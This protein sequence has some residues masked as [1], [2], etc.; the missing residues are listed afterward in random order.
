MRPAPGTKIELDGSGHCHGVALTVDNRQMCRPG[1][2]AGLVRAQ[3]M[4]N[5]FVTQHLAG[6]A[7]TGRLGRRESL[8]GTVPN[9]VRMQQFIDWYAD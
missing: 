3:Y 6:I 7:M 9:I 4:C 8:A 5:R 2:L 1:G